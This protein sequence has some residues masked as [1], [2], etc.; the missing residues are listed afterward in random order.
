MLARNARGGPSE[1][2]HGWLMSDLKRRR[3]E[4]SKTDAT[5][6]DEHLAAICRLQP[7]E[8]CAEV[9]QGSFAR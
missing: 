7:A 3:V 5:A 9:P 8:A 4:L 1:I 2:E 6:G